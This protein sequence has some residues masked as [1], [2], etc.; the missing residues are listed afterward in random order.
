VTVSRI[1]DTCRPLKRDLSQLELTCEDS[2]P[3]SSDLT[4][5]SCASSSACTPPQSSDAKQRFQHGRRCE[6]TRLRLLHSCPSSNRHTMQCPCS[7][8]RLCA[9]SPPVS[10]KTSTGVAAAVLSTVYLSQG[11]SAQ[12][13]TI[14]GARQAVVPPLKS[15]HADCLF[16]SRDIHVVECSLS[17]SNKMT[18]GLEHSL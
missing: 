12:S 17:S 15:Q 9:Q 13:H 4:V 11:M 6:V 7:H 1:V 8:L 3:A 10:I 2:E 16:A 5:P 14:A 18:Q